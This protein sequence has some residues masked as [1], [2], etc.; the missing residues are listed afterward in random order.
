MKAMN[1]RW[2]LSSLGAMGVAAKTLARGAWQEAGGLSDHSRLDLQPAARAEVLENTRVRIEVDS[3][4]GDFVTLANKTT[5]RSYISHPQ[6]ARSFRL[7][8]WSTDR[9]SETFNGRFEH[10]IESS[11]QNAPRLTRTQL[12]NAEQIE[13]FYSQLVAYERE[14]SISFW[15]SLT[16]PTDSDEFTYQCRVVNNSPYMVTQVFF[17]WIS[18]IEYVER[19]NEDRIVFCNQKLKVSD[20]LAQGSYFGWLPG[21]FA[22]SYPDYPSSGYHFQLPWVHYGGEHEGLYVA[23]RDHSGEHHRFYMQNEYDMKSF[24]KNRMIY[25]VA[26]NFCP[27]LRSGEWQ[28]PELVLS[29]HQGDWHAAADRFRESLKSWYQEPETPRSFRESIG[30]ANLIFRKNFTELVEMARDAKQYGVNDVTAWQQDVLYPRP[31]TKDDPGNYRIGI[32]EEAWGGLERLRSCNEAVRAMGM[33]T[34]VIFNS[35]L[36]VVASLEEGLRQKAEEWALHGWDGTARGG[37]LV[38]HTLWSCYGASSVPYID[39]PWEFSMG[40]LQMCPAVDEFKEF[41]LR[42][43]ADAIA[44]T[45]YQGHFFDMSST[46]PV[47]FN[48]GHGHSSPK[49]PSEQMPIMMRELKSRMRQNDPQAL[50]VGEGA[51]MRATQY[52]D[53]CWLWNVWGLDNSRDYAL[54]ILRYSL[55]WVRLAVA[56]DDNIGLANRFF[57]MGIYLAFFNRNWH[58]E[59]S[60]LSDWPEFSQHIR[61]LADL[62]KLLLE[63]LVDGQFMDDLGL[64]CKAGYAKLYQRP[65]R[66]AV[67]VAETEGK[68]QST[69]IQLDAA[70]YDIRTTSGHC[71]FVGFSGKR[72]PS[73]LK[74]MGAGQLRVEMNLE[75][76]ETGALIFDR[77]HA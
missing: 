26:W 17:P 18:G 3:V 71:Q 14:L 21:R 24:D 74:R 55:P 56:L 77:A 48:S 75:P 32:V 2:F 29:P 27:Y 41:T 37:P 54:E 30:S 28:S 53:L 50:L 19:R 49:A 70:R 23:S 63:F 31:L 4:N 25:S 60:K 64:Q 11:L 6:Y 61:K 68:R 20:A 51:E 67:L 65:D 9:L 73:P 7:V 33:T 52:Y 59:T 76:W 13:V 47:C 57:V 15:Y 44:Q 72:H 43:V 5:G 38:D 35:L 36:Y 58:C 22:L 66:V 12:V 1:R 39:N 8:Y 46:D 42:N 62:R 45:K 16:L 10:A 40:M 69:R 34:V